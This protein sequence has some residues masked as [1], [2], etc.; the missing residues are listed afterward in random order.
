MEGIEFD[1][2]CYLLIICWFSLTVASL[3]PE[4]DSDYYTLKALI[5]EHDVIFALTDSR[6]ARLACYCMLNI[7]W[8]YYCSKTI[9]S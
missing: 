9:M 3:V 6:E 8:Y 4:E 1:L 5:E 2:M 7:C